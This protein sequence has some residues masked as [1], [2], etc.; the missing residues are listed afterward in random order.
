V[1]DLAFLWSD[2]GD[3][4]APTKLYL[5]MVSVVA[6]LSKRNDSVELDLPESQNWHDVMFTMDVLL[7]SNL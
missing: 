4:P 3:A 5:P 2:Q 1:S 7:R 6:A